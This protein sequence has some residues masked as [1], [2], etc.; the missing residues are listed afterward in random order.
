MKIKLDENLGRSCV[1]LFENTG[2]DIETVATENLCG[3]DDR[4]LIGICQSE[5]RCLV[6]MD[7]DFAN[8]IVFPPSDYSGIAVIRMSKQPFIDELHAAIGT[9]VTHLK[10]HPIS[11]RLWIIQGHRIREYLPEN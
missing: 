9:L 8:P 1:A 3:I 11:G 7:L 6:T 4:S 5:E 10:N 2:F